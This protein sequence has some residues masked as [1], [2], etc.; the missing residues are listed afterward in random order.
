MN[1]HAE[2]AAHGYILHLPFKV[3]GFLGEVKHF[4]KD[5]FWN[6]LTFTSE[7]SKNFSVEDVFNFCGE[8]IGT[9][10]CNFP[11]TFLVEGS[12]MSL[13]KTIMRPST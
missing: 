7:M 11:R 8:W 6:F 13:G 4:M 12:G 9:P 3:L 1:C 5:T 10:L 2:Y